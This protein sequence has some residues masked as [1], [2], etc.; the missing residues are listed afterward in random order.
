MYPSLYK[1]LESLILMIN[2]TMRF[3]HGQKKKHHTYK[4]IID[5]EDGAQINQ[6]NSAERR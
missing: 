3:F 6:L 5:E 2:T 4:T 1:P